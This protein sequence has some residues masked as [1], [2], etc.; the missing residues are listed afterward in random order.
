MGE[1][2]SRLNVNHYLTRFYG[3]FAA[4]KI[5]MNQVRSTRSSVSFENAD[6]LV[7]QKS[8]EV[9][10]GDRRKLGDVSHNALAPV[11]RLHAQQLPQQLPQQQAG[12]LAV[13]RQR[14]GG[15]RSNSASSN[16]SRQLNSVSS[17]N[18]IPESTPA[19]ST[20][21]LKDEPAEP[22]TASLPTTTATTPSS[23]TSETATG[24]SLKAPPTAAFVPTQ[25]ASSSAKSSLSSASTSAM[26]VGST[27]SVAS[28]PASAVSSPVSGSSGGLVTR[29]EFEKNRKVTTFAATP[30][31]QKRSGASLERKPSRRRSLRKAGTSL[32]RSAR[33]AAIRARDKMTPKKKKPIV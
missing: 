10:V 24:L 5:I 22:I 21:Q 11:P 7:R 19:R 29:E 25:S 20:T 9:G 15:S 3:L 30:P 16:G 26:D 2:L 4:L 1:L 23:S 8:S 28:A 18:S 31:Q 13:P 33:K 32:V 14:F 17:L 12:N 27:I 6:Q